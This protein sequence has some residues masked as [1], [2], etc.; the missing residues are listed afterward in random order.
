MDRRSISLPPV[1]PLS[2]IIITGLINRSNKVVGACQKKGKKKYANMSCTPPNLQS[3]PPPLHP[4][5][6]YFEWDG[7]PL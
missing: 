3:P 4:R 5:P 6:P 1:V 2:Y 7:G